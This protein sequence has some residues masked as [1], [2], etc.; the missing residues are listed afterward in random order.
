MKPT[1][2]LAIF[3]ALILTV[4]SSPVIFNK[5]QESDSVNDIQPPVEDVEESNRTKF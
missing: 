4:Q 3:L 5:R 2:V 1:L